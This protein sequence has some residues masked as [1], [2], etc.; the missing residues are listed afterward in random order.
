MKKWIIFSLLTLFL[1]TLSGCYERE[2][3]VYTLEDVQSQITEIYD[4]VAP[5]TVAVVSYDE[6]DYAIK[7]GHGSGL[8]Y[9]RVEAGGLYTY[10]VITNYHVVASQ[11]YIRVYNGSKYYNAT[12][13]AVHEPEDLALVTF[14]TTDDLPFYGIDQFSGNKVVTPVVGSFVI[15]VGT[16]LDLD[17]FNTATIGIVGRTSNARIVQHD[18]AINPGNSGGPLF[19]LAGNLLGFNTWKRTTTITSDG[20]I[21]VDGIGFAISM[22][23]AKSV[24]TSLRVTQT[25]VFESAKI[26]ITVMNISDAI[27]NKFGGI[28]PVFIEE[29]QTAGVFV[30]S[31]VPLRPAVGKLFVNDII[32]HVNDE[33]IVNLESLGLLLSGMKFGDTLNLTVRRYINN[34]F[35][36][37]QVSITV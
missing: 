8:I 37:V 6:A 20:E 21:A 34:E 35:V 14:A 11:A 26:G 18:A 1:F 28:R 24:I 19:D 17:F 33:V 7:V 32:T 12:P 22:T 4:R 10:Y 29:G 16:P 5:M 2:T 13:F 23:V 25:S 36:T 27:T 30:D 31:I 15:A 3:T 9:D